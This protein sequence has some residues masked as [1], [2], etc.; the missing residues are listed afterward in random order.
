MGQT[1]DTPVS[2]KETHRGSNDFSTFGCSCMQGYRISMED[3]HNNIA[4][5]EF[6]EEKKKQLG[7]VE[8]SFYAVYDGHSGDQAADYCSK[9]LL[10]NII[11]EDT[12][13]DGS[14]FLSNDALIQSAFMKTDAELIKHSLQY[15]YDAGTTAVTT[16]IKRQNEE[17]EII[18]ANTGDSRC[19]LYHHGK[20]VPLSH[21]HKPTNE[22]E[23]RR[24]QDSGGFVEFSRVN[25]TLAV[26]R[27][28]GDL[29]YKRN[30]KVEP[31]EQA[32][33]AKPDIKRV[34]F[35]LNSIKDDY[36]FLILAC[37]GVWDVM[38][39]EAAAEFVKKK[40]LEQKQGI[41][42]YKP[43][44]D[45][46]EGEKEEQKQEFKGYDVGLICEQLLD[47]CVIELDSKDNV[48]VIIVLFNPVK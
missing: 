43:Q 31:H 3:R 6:S 19:V 29:S 42:T 16:L 34:K 20:V 47:R 5:V 32:V 15:G 21:D 46:K 48:S 7:D 40:L 4:K 24:I 35:N 39:N 45:A 44:E 10:K 30:T 37:D 33:I 9:N 36:A 12:S 17:V 18:C 28:F 1:L 13:T 41:Y 25:G 23:R 27:A 38:S 2:E 8:L 11:E 22:E 26:S 14:S